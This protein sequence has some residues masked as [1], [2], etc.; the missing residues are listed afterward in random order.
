[1]DLESAWAVKKRDEGSFSGGKR[2]RALSG[3]QRIQGLHH[4]V[5]YETVSLSTVGRIG[6]EH[7]GVCSGP[8]GII[9]LT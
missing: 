5:R 2:D 8:E 6:R 9:K 7:P 4:G 3:S 1:M